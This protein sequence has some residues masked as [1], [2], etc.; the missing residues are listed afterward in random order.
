MQ[1]VFRQPTHGERRCIGAANHDRAGLFQIRHGWAIVLRDFV[2]E[3]DSAVVGGTS[4]LIRVDF[5]GDRHPVQGAECIAPGNSVVGSIRRRPRLR[6]K[7][8]YNCIEHRV[9]GFYTFQMGID[10]FPRR[11]LTRSD[12]M[13]QLHGIALPQGALTFLAH[14]DLHF[15]HNFDVS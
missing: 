1:R 6:R 3:R 5:G 10:D 2:L 8:K 12:K 15:P 14:A 9:H 11:H 7:R 4:S 13:R